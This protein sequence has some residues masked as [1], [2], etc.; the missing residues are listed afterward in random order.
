MY[1]IVIP[2]NNTMLF[3]CIYFIYCE[4]HLGSLCFAITDNIGS[5]WFQF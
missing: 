5:F 4:G 2:W 1:L 3:H